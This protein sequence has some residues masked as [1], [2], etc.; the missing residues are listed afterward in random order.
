MEDIQCSIKPPLTHSLTTFQGQPVWSATT[1]VNVEIADIND[2]PPVFTQHFQDTQIPENI[3]VGSSILKI[4]ASDGDKGVN[5]VHSYAFSSNVPDKFAID[6][7]TG[8]VTIANPLDYEE[9][10][11]YILKVSTNDGA[12]NAETP[13]TIAVTDVND[14]PPHFSQPQYRFNLV[15]RQA[16]NTFIGTV[17][18]TD[19]DS[20][21]PNSEVYY[22]FKKPT[23]EFSLDVTSGK[24][25]SRMELLYKF[26]GN[27]PSPENLH[28][29]TVQALDRGEPPLSSEVVVTVEIKPAN[30]YAPV[31]EKTAYLT[32]VAQNA[33]MGYSI[34]R[35]EAT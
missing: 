19:R 28:K 29:L 3:P 35:L 4:T 26:S 33:P 25:Y 32:A 1:I 13:V 22:I 15:E 8:V 12:H 17:K 14:N 5:A 18:A 23:K 21:G 24:I 6:R 2:K 20:R 34:L 10:N 7:H 11:N 31:L 30:K 27:R 9:K 16:K